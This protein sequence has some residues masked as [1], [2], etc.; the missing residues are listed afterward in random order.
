MVLFV[1]VRLPPRGVDADTTA[2]GRSGH[3]GDVQVGEADGV[4]AGGDG[5]SELPMILTPLTDIGEPTTA[6][7]AKASIV[8]AVTTPASR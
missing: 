1:S 5:E 6:V 4:V 2:R 3:P 7:F 8:M